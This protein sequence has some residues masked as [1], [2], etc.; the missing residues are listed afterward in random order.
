MTKKPRKLTDT[1]LASLKAAPEGQRTSFA[2]TVV[3]GLKVRVTDKGAKSYVLWRRYNGSKNPA[4][5]SLGKVGTLTLAE[6][7]DKARAWLKLIVKGEDPRAV[8]R[9]ERE[10]KL[11]SN[12]NTFGKAFEEYLEQHVKGL[13][14]AADIEREMKKDLLSRWKDRPLAEIS[15]R[16]VKAMIAAV[17]KRGPYQAHNLLGHTRTFFNWAI[18]TD[19]YGIETSPTDHIKPGTTIGRKKSRQRVLTD[20][21]IKAFWFATGKLGYPF[22]TLFR[23]LLMTGQRRSE[24]AESSWPEFN[25]PKRILTIPPE[26]FKSDSEHLVP[27]TSEMMTLLETIPRWNAG[28]FLF[29]TT[30][31]TAQVNGFSY[32]KRRL[33]NIMIGAL[34]DFELKP[35]VLH[36]LRRT[37]RTRLASL[38]VRDEVAEMIIGHG[39]KGLQR[40]YD[41]HQYV[42][43]MREALTA[44]SIRLREIVA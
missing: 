10:A 34:G 31:G 33:D 30:N 1:F 19:D 28:D 9:R 22:G 43:E 16:D 13:R 41:Q 21:E 44:W 26:R 8:E 4:A 35:W 29:S 39:R 40:V 6:A 38:K 24:I 37:V 12:D 25:L 3:P 36:D 32:Q 15:R 17:Q 42:D 14:K 20:P 5:R 11:I 27:L 18:D 7:R 23:L 2:D